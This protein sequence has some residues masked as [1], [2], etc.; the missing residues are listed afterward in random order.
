M[1]EPIGVLVKRRARR[2]KIGVVCFLV[3]MAL[4]ATA[5]F[6]LSTDPT[7]GKGAMGIVRG[8]GAELEAVFVGPPELEVKWD[9]DS[10]GGHAWSVSLIEGRI[11]NVSGKTVMFRDIVYCVKDG[12]GQVIWEQS[13]G[14]FTDGGRLRPMEYFNFVSN[15]V[16]KRESKIFE[17]FVKDAVVLGR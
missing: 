9:I 11:R 8:T 2:R 3:L 1:K 6:I 10:T 17:V 14:R 15:P 12:G 5:Y 4:A 7:Q 13:D 16:T